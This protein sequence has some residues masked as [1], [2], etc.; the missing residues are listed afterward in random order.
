M[1][2]T[3]EP[4]K[5]SRSDSWVSSFHFRVATCDLWRF[6][7][8]CVCSRSDVWLLTFPTCENQLWSRRL[9]W[10][11]RFD[12][13]LT[14]V[15][16]HQVRLNTISSPSWIGPIGREHW[17]APS[18]VAVRLAT[19]KQTIC[20]M[21]VRLKQQLFSRDSVWLCWYWRLERAGMQLIHCWVENENENENDYLFAL[22]GLGVRMQS[23]LV[24]RLQVGTTRQ[25]KPSKQESGARAW[26]A[27][28]FACAPNSV[29]R[30]SRLAH[31]AHNE[32]HAELAEERSTWRANLAHHLPLSCTLM[33][34]ETLRGR[35]VG[36]KR[37]AC[38]TRAMQ[39]H[40]HFLCVDKPIWSQ[41][42]DQRPATTDATRLALELPDPT[43]IFLILLVHFA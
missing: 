19:P 12:G 36:S 3:S 22:C 40:A 10:G 37:N 17:H 14:S 16:A 42:S 39:T 27:H 41:M 9:D 11:R 34:D 2:S 35:E 33:I 18:F 5:I 43:K 15:G 29:S 4:K 1:G 25:T 30:D 28:E 23:V 13:P 38:K 24:V 21:A 6:R 32:K 31:I 20:K 7:F 8:L 26:I